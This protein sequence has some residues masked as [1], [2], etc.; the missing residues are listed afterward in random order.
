MR[1]VRAARVGEGAGPVDAT[2]LVRRE[3]RS[4][5]HPQDDAPAAIEITAIDHVVLTVGDLAATVDFYERVLGLRAFT[6]AGGARTALELGHQKLNLHE[7][8]HEFF[9]NAR[10]ARPGS[11]D[12]CLLTDTPPT[13][14]ITLATHGSNLARPYAAD[15]AEGPRVGWIAIPTATSRGLHPL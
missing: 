13:S 7:L 10:E 4:R 3:R 12:V 6:F 5:G 8:G 9:L 11:A 15:C 1:C 14:P 2:G